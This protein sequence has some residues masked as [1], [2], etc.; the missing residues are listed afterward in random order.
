MQWLHK[1]ASV[2]SSLG[3]SDALA[4]RNLTSSWNALLPSS[5]YSK[6]CRIK[7]ALPIST[8]HPVEFI[9]HSGSVSV[10]SSVMSRFD[11]LGTSSIIGHLRTVVMP[12]CH[13]SFDNT[14]N[15]F[16]LAAFRSNRRLDL[17]WLFP[18]CLCRNFYYPLPT[19]VNH[20]NFC[21]V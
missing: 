15:I 11:W 16:S 7:Y 20:L 12:A 19:D 3:H 4:L 14:T 5:L 9:C 1:V 2:F 6:I 13:Q 18:S 10:H 21:I 17:F 8:P